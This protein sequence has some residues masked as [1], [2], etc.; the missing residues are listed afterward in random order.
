[1]S[2]NALISHFVHIICNVNI[3]LF[4]I[5]TSSTFKL[6]FCN[7]SAK[8][9]FR[10]IYNTFRSLPYPCSTLSYNLTF[11]DHLHIFVGQSSPPFSSTVCFQSCQL[12][13]RIVFIS[14][15]VLSIHLR[16]GRPLL[17][18]PGTTMSIIFLERLF[19]SVL[20]KFNIFCPLV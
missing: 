2:A 4:F 17:L 15:R 18:F 19:S 5:C 10:C 20:S 1:M 16:L 6:H 13:V 12:S 11:I 8:Y 9:F 7:Q 3:E 14:S